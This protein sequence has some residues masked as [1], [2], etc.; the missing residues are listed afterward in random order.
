MEMVKPVREHKPRRKRKAPGS[1][2]LGGT[3]PAAALPEPSPTI[4]HNVAKLSRSAPL[5]YAICVSGML[6]SHW[7]KSLGDLSITTETAPNQNAV[8]WLRGEVRDQAALVGLIDRLFDL[9]TVL[10]LVDCISARGAAPHAE[11]IS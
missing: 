5:T 7:A 10:V 2:R 11:P 4:P 1:P 8:T 6:D 9:G 3:V